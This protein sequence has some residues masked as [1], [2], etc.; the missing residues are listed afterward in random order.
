MNIAFIS[1]PFEYIHP[2]DIPGSIGIWTDRFIQAS[3]SQNMKFT[4]F[5]HLFPGLPVTE[6][7]DDV[8]Y[9]YIDAS[10]DEKIFRPIRVAERM[11]GFPRKRKPFFSSPLSN[12]WY[13]HRITREIRESTLDLIHIHN[14]SQFVPVIRKS[15]PDIKIV[16][17]MHCE[18]L[19]QLDA[20][21]IHKR[22]LDCD[23]ILGCSDYITNKIRDKFPDQASKCK[24]AYNG[25]DI[26][27]FSGNGP[28]AVP[29]NSTNQLLFVGRVSPEK[30]LHI[31]LKAFRKV[32]DEEPDSVLSIAGTPGD[33]PYEFIVLISDDPEVKKLRVFYKGLL[34]KG[35]YFEHLHQMLDDQMRKNTR[36]LGFL[37]H[38]DLINT[39]QNSNVLINPSVSEAFGMS[40]V[41]AMAT[42]TPV[43]ATRVG[44]MVEI[45]NSG[46]LGLL[47]EPGDPDSL[48]EKILVLLRD[49]ETRREISRTGPPIARNTFAW[50]QIAEKVNH[51]YRELF[52]Q[53][54]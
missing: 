40:L 30:G 25:V 1:Q 8:D 7:I 54:G 36:F 34:K 41:E 9:R 38:T 12:Y 31:L 17:H 27:I 49:P 2:P 39:Y 35:E 10:L 23:L 53:N 20:E 46:N 44:G 3:K 11:T 51:H 5:A 47:A 22:L 16:L 15:N 42:G 4:V 24:T 32:L 28:G 48:A 50:D 13:I 52:Q 45:M 6:T 33:V 18:W 19:T 14:Y 26:N 37:S 21:M 29:N 43:V